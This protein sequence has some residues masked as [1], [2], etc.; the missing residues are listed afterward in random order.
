MMTQLE[1]EVKLYYPN[2]EQ[3]EATLREYAEQLHDRVYEQNIRYDLDDNSLTKRGVV[4]RLRQD[5]SVKLTYKEPGNIER[6]IIT[7][8]ELEVEVS[9]FETMEKILEKFGYTPA[10]TYEKYRTTYLWHGTQIMLDELPY[11]NFIE[12]EGSSDNIERVLD[13]LGLTDVQR[14][15]DSYSKLFDYVKHHLGLNFRDLTFDNFADVDVPEGAFI[16]P[17]SIVIR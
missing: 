10:M 14:R 5:H 12:V 9:D 6:G 8:E 13:E 11:G 4:V 1:T 17:G 3:L 7:R 15:E 16:P 2:L